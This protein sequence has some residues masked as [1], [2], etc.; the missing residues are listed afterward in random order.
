MCRTDAYT[1]RE[2]IKNI[3][4]TA[5]VVPDYNERPANMVVKKSTR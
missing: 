2:H 4:Q 1:V 3:D 5:P